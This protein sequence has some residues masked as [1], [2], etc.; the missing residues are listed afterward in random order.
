MTAPGATVQSVIGISQERLLAERVAALYTM[1]PNN[2]GAHLVW[3]GI[4]LA[5]LHDMMPLWLMIAWPSALLALCAARVPLLRGYA[6]RPSSRTP[7][8]WGWIFSASTLTTG[9]VWGLGTGY[10]ALSGSNWQLLILTAMPL[11][12]VVAATTNGT[13]LPAFLGHAVGTLVPLTAALLLRPDGHGF[14]LGLIIL[15][16][17]PIL[18]VFA[19]TIGGIITQSLKLRLENRELIDDLAAARIKADAANQAKS[20]FLANMSH[21][22]RTPMNGV[23]GMCQLLLQTPLE[24]KQKRFAATIMDSAKALL[25]I[26]NDILDISKAESGMMVLEDEPVDMKKLIEDALGRVEGIALIK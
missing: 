1:N 13:F 10:L 19:R 6:R 20:E 22:I 9:L 25:G 15:C 7:T 16:S 14:A 21:E 5:L 24:E 11:L 26:I 2:L 12:A 3:M 23:M 8:M 4:I 18:T 17:L